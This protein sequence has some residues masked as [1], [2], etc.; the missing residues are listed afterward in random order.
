[1]AARFLSM[2]VTNQKY[3][4]QLVD[5]KFSIL[6]LENGVLVQPTESW[7]MKRGRDGTERK[8]A[9]TDLKKG[10]NFEFHVIK[11]YAAL[12]SDFQDALIPFTLPDFDGPQ[13]SITVEVLRVSSDVVECSSMVKSARSEY[14]SCEQFAY[15]TL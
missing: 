9:A 10:T 12:I 14:I 2:A 3:Y 5:T 11:N 7:K 15:C 8:L 13:Y 4:S 6:S 1:M